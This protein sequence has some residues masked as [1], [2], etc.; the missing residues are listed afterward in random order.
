MFKK[1]TYNFQSI[2]H[3]DQV[4]PI[5][6]ETDMGHN[7]TRGY[8]SLNLAMHVLG[9]KSGYQLIDQPSKITSP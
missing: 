3:Y 5:K 1:C 4:K 7:E 2:A 6:K 8:F 9:C